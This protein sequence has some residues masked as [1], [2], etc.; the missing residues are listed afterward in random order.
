ML[1]GG[2]PDGDHP[3]KDRRLEGDH[4]EPPRRVKRLCDVRYFALRD[5][6]G[7]YKGTL[8]VVQDVTKIRELTGERRL[9]DW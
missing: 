4:P 9:L 1:E 6:E 2:A 3:F 7:S 8:E 5:R